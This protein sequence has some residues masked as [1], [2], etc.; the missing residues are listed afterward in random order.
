MERGP[1]RRK[2]LMI[3]YDRERRILLQDR[4]DISKLGEEW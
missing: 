4:R 3:F 2:A 1:D